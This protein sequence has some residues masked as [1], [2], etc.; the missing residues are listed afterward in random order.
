MIKN[1]PESALL[2][3]CGLGKTIITLM[4]IVE[5]GLHRGLVIAPRTVADTVWEQEAA[6]WKQTS[7]LTFARVLGDAKH[8][9]AALDKEADIY[10]I[11][12]DNVVWLKERLDLNWF[13]MIVFDESSSFKNH[14]AKRT[15]AL[16]GLTHPRKIILTATPVPKNLLD[17]FAQYKI[18]DCGRTLGNKYS[19]FRDTY[20]VNHN[21]YFPD[22][23]PKLGAEVA[24]FDLIAP[25]TMSMRSKDLLQLPERIDLTSRVEMD[26]KEYQAYLYFAKQSVIKLLEKSKEKNPNGD[27]VTLTAANSGVLTNKLAQFANGFVYWTDEETGEKSYIDIHHHKEEAMEYILE[28]CAGECVVVAYQFKHDLERLFALADKMGLRALDLRVSENIIK[29]NAGECDIAFLH[30]KSAGF[31]LNLQGPSHRLVWYALPWSYEEYE[32]TN[33][34]IYRQGQKHTTFIHNIECVGTVDEDIIEALKCKQGFNDRMKS[35]TL[36]Y[37]LGAT[38]EI[39]LNDRVKPRFAF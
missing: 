16:F 11:S 17:L 33:A 25:E 10:L 26:Y 29:Y 28:A 1:N 7:H 39:T 13:D 14:T 9:A 8:R 20:F 6:K 30:P 27:I 19:D 24:I 23:K 3:D 5:M 2:L 31:G 34:R 12:R 36:A 4:S 22:Y 37:A 15:K 21:P 35:S 18:L 32:Q 38:G